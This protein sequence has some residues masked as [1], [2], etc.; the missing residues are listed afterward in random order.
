M[1]PPRAWVRWLLGTIAFFLPLAV[2]RT[3]LWLDHSPYRHHPVYRALIPYVVATAV[4]L[5]MIVP[6]AFVLLAKQSWIRRV[7]LVLLICGLL[8]VQ[9]YAIFVMVMMNM[10]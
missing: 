6:T 1:K 4:G 5:A 3:G 8:A 9:C 2:A 10:H 7:G